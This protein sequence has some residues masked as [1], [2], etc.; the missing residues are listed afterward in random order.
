MGKFFRSVLKKV[1][2]EAAE[3]LK[4]ER[5]PEPRPRHCLAFPE[6]A[7]EFCSEFYKQTAIEVF[8]SEVLFFLEFIKNQCEAENEQNNG[9]F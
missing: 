3:C 4:P 7:C 8:P 6:N 9:D 5:Q 2:I 1:G